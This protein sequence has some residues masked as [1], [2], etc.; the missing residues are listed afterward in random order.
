M[1]SSFHQ[2]DLDLCYH[3]LSQSP[4]ASVISWLDQCPYP[5]SPDQVD[6][7]LEEQFFEVGES[8]YSRHPLNTTLTRGA[9]QSITAMYSPTK[10]PRNEGS[11]E[12]SGFPI[13]RTPPPPIRRRPDLTR[14]PLTVPLTTGVDESSQAPSSPRTSQNRSTGSN[15]RQQKNAVKKVLHLRSF[16]TP[17]R[18]RPL[19]EEVLPIAMKALVQTIAAVSDSQGG[20]FPNQTKVSILPC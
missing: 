5:T 17:V 19:D 13:A 15:S 8:K 3:Q 4:N 10:R 20:I 6:L 16:D 12:G 18:Y 14:P 7:T 9:A 2:S 11:D 1:S